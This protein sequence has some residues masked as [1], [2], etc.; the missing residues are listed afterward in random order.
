MKR[1]FVITI[2][3]CLVVFTASQVLAKKQFYV[4]PTA[5]TGGSYYP[6]GALMASLWS[7]N[8]KDK[9][10]V[11]TS[12]SSGGSVENCNMMAA[13]ENI[14]G[15][16]AID[17]AMSANNGTGKFKGRAYKGIRIV[18][19]LFPTYQSWG[20][21]FDSKITTTKDM[22]GKRISL[23]KSGSA[24]VRNATE[25]LAAAG[26]TV[27]DLG[28][29]EYIGWS[30]A[31]QGMKDGKLDGVLLQ[32]APP[33][34][35]GIDLY[36]SKVGRIIP[37]TDGEIEKMT[38]PGIMYKVTMKA[39]TYPN[40]SDDIQTVARQ[41][42]FI[43][44]ASASEELIYQLTKIMFDNLKVLQKAHNAFRKIDPAQPF[45]GT[46]QS[47]MKLHPGAIRY[48]KEKGIAVPANMIP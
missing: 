40:Q 21:T 36:S 33:T 8:L 42:I 15:M 4:L 27:K 3:L 38:A 46:E 35:A 2:V 39:G 1:F 24:S 23:G 48:Y 30:Q 47:G 11:V 45:G 44:D 6:M 20:V 41:N 5:S 34:A 28:K 17:V 13:G 10:I 12:Q 7:D 26:L 14:L 18:S 37:L 9:D 19:I 31:V 22:K 25:L 32:G 43:A 16:S 29:A